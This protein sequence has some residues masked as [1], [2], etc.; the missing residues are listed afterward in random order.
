MQIAWPLISARPG[1]LRGFSVIELLVTLAVAAVLIALALP[2]FTHIARQHRL[3]SV[4]GEFM[5]SV[6]FAR[7]EAMRLGQDIVIRRR[8][9]CDLRLADTADWSCGWQVFA[10]TN[11][12]RVRDRNE[13]E[14]QT[15]SP[16]VGARFRKAGAGSAQYIQFDR[17]GRLVIFGQRFAALPE[18]GAPLDGV[19]ICFSTGTRLRTVWHAVSCGD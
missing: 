17:F 11:G 16:P 7:V 15:I 10:D 9:P 13:A 2:S 1:R 3:N 18:G 12:N 5:A 6:R 19:L 14:L 4:A 8:A